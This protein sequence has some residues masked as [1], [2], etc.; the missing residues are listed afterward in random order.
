MKDIGETQIQY[1]KQQI[2]LL[3]NANTVKSK[4][5]RRLKPMSSKC[6]MCSGSCL[7]KSATKDITENKKLDV[8][9][10]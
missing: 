10:L 4:E 9:H 2:C 1:V 5:G 6:N 7:Q 8:S 3:Q